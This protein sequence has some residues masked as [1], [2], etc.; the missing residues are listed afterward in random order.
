MI[1][2]TLTEERPRI[3]SAPEPHERAR[4]GRRAWAAQLGYEQAAASL[5]PPHSARARG[6]GS[7]GGGARGEALKRRFGE[8]LGEDLAGVRLHLRSGLADA[9]DAHG[10]AQQ[11]HVH[12]DLDEPELGSAHGQRVLAHELVHVAQGRLSGVAPEPVVEREADTLA[13]TL[14]S[15]GRGRAQ[16]PSDPRRPLYKKRRRRRPAARARQ[17]RRE[18][19]RAARRR[20]HQPAPTPNRM[21]QAARFNG[22]R[23]FS[24]RTIRRLREALQPQAPTGWSPLARTLQGDP[25]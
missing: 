10:I 24:H 8:L 15:G 16:A 18:R 25:R 4:G 3:E 17:R 22:A 2:A 12:L 13:D 11:G 23:G 7:P 6:G 21:L 5:R 9:A 19:R 20:P 1:G 14:V